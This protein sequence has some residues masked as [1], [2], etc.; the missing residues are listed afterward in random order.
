MKFGHFQSQKCPNY[1]FNK[2]LESGRKS[3]LSREM[4]K[5]TILARELL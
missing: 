5:E 2:V 3:Y 4:V 1:L